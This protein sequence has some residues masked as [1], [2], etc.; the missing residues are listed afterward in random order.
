M[1]PKQTM[2]DQAKNLK[3]LADSLVDRAEDLNSIAR[4]LEHDAAFLPDEPGGTAVA[5]PAPTFVAVP[6]TPSTTATPGAW[7]GIANHPGDPWISKPGT[8]NETI[9]ND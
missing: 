1:T 9:P 8:S 6:A 5:T 7:D 4:V 3:A 2:I